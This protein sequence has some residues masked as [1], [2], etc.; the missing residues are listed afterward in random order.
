MDR[1]KAPDGVSIQHRDG[2]FYTTDDWVAKGFS[3]DDANGVAVKNEQCG[4]VIAKTWFDGVPWSSDASNLVN[5]ILTTTSS[6]EAKMDFA[7]TAN[8]ELMIATDTSGAA[9][10]CRNY[11]FPNGAKGYL[12]AAGEADVITQNRTTINSAIALINGSKIP[13]NPIWSSTQYSS[14][15]AWMA[16]NRSLAEMG[17]K[18]AYSCYTVVVTAIKN[19]P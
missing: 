3:N 5:G 4:F 7:G 6:A 15:D 11:T 8:T 19:N 10:V 9:Y 16:W 2:K 18:Q 1:T 13:N 12:P 14:T 17:K